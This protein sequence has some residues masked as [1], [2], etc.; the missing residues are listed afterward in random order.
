MG[1][2]VR[3]AA[4]YVFWSVARAY[5]SHVIAPFA[6]MLAESLVVVSLTDREVSIRRAASAAFQENAG[7]HGLF[8][9]GIDV[10]TTADYFSIGNR[11]NCFTDI[12]LKISE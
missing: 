6:Q 3:D 5:E 4:C 1:T 2:N 8:P 12:I 7:R 9:R 10:V 11:I